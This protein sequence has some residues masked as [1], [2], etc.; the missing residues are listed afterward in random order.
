MEMST[1][2]QVTGVVAEK[3]AQGTPEVARHQAVYYWVYRGICVTCK[4]KH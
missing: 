4:Q 3:F 2:V 1:R